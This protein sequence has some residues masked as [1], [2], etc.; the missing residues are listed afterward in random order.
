MKK[1]FLCLAIVA[2]I[3]DV[4]AQQSWQWGRRGGGAQDSGPIENVDA[5]ATDSVGNVYAISHLD[6]RGS[7]N[8]DISGRTLN[9]TGIQTV[10]SSF[11]CNGDLRWKEIIGTGGYD[12]VY[13]LKTDAGGGVYLSGQFS[14]PNPVTP[15]VFGS[16]TTYAKE[17]KKMFLAKCD[18][19]GTFKWFRQPQSDTISVTA[20]NQTDDLKYM[21]VDGEGNVYLLCHLRKGRLGTASQPYDVATPGMHIL[22]YSKNGDFLGGTMLAISLD[23]AANPLG[24]SMSWELTRAPSGK[25]IVTGSIDNGSTALT[26]GT[27]SITKWTF[28]A[29]FNA[30]GSL[31]WLQQSNLPFSSGSHGFLV[32]AVVDKLGDVY[33]TGGTVNGDGFGSITFSNPIATYAGANIPMAIKLN[34]ANG[35]VIWGKAAYNTVESWSTSGAVN[36]AGEFVIAG[37]WLGTMYWPGNV[38][39][40]V[41]TQPNHRQLFLARFNGQ[42]GNFIKM[43]TLHNSASTGNVSQI[44]AQ[45]M[46][47]DNNGN[48]YVG[49]SFEKSLQVGSALLTGNG[50]GIQDFFIAKYGYNN[51]SR[52]SGV[53]VTGNPVGGV[54]LFVAPNPS[55]TET[56][57]SY[58][59]NSNSGSLEFYDLAGRMLHRKVLTQKTGIEKLLLTNYV[60]GLYLV[61]LREAGQV[62]SHQRLSVV[63]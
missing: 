23:V 9:G 41:R 17:N 13:A 16:D 33:V 12:G 38:A 55:T 54:E 51:C 44:Q 45:A 61:V 22:R 18:S 3:S 58:Q 6:F 27:T 32:A 47:A 63:R 43:D 53:G 1:L 35:T 30:D 14:N 31:G 56:R 39:D 20:G 49:G 4:Q 25:Y 5:I 40:S 19:N 48:V 36:T 50:T 59:L 42:S 34:G 28:I 8:V 26:V 11:A 29:S 21:D 46:A 62:V 24:P 37:R 52:P 10:L 2:G 7:N 57:V 15:F 60:P